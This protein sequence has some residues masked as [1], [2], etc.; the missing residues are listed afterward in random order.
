MHIGKLAGLA[1]VF[2]GSLFAQGARYD[3]TSTT[4]NASC[5]P[6]SLCPVLAIPGTAVSVCIGA[7]SSLGDC[8]S[9]PAVTYSNFS[10]T[11][12]CPSTAQLTPAAGG[13]CS[14]TSDSTGAF[15]FWVGTAGTFSY[16][17]SLPS[18]GTYGPYIVTP[19]GGLVS[20]VS[21]IN[22]TLTGNVVNVVL[23]TLANTFTQPQTI[24]MSSASLNG[25]HVINAGGGYSAL[26][27]T[28]TVAID[29]PAG[30]GLIALSAA[31]TSGSGRVRTI[32]YYTDPPG[33][34]T[35]RWR[36]GTDLAPES[37]ANAGSNYRVQGCTD[38]GS[39]S[40][41][42]TINRATGLVTVP[43][44]LTVVG[45]LSAGSVTTTGSG[46]FGPTVIIDASGGSEMLLSAAATN[47][48]GRIRSVDYFTD[49]IGS[50][51]F[52]W[53]VGTDLAPEA[54]GN[55]GSNFRIQGCTDAGSCSNYLAITRSS[56][57][58]NI[59]NAL[60]VGSFITVTGTG[61]FGGTGTAT[62]GLV[63]LLDASNVATGIEIIETIA[64]VPTREADWNA[65]PTSSFSVVNNIGT[66][67]FI[68]L[69]GAGVRIPH[70]PGGTG[71]LAACFDGSFNL[72]K[73][74]TGGCP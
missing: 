46:T 32:D 47:I 58:V 30:G 70:T 23:T 15:G 60:T 9:N 13:A 5:A 53:R 19:G 2:S 54:G 59:P 29:I 67:D 31:A 68:V 8:Q 27:E 56:G 12:A 36:A 18:G 17:I 28:G 14:A 33:S 61:Q 10:I 49:P 52:R 45:A 55:A 34:A 44:A 48:S 62:T 20:G 71:G 64:S 65:T 1:V 40:D 38:A 39:C 41:D 21:S 72:Y 66:N 35:I 24:S 11:T 73:S 51:T 7:R 6:G 22:T 63:T 74:T 25:L 3:S 26:F 16:F 4:T 50:G 57:L 42:I 69:Q 43:N 37:G